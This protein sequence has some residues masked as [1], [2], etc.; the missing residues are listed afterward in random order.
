MATENNDAAGEV[1]EGSGAR[2][3]VNTC[4]RRHT[5]LS[6]KMSGLRRAP[7]RTTHVPGSDAS[8]AVTSLT[9]AHSPVS[10]SSVLGSVE[11]FIAAKRYSHVKMSASGTCAHRGLPPRV[12]TAGYHRP[13]G[14]C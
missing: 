2:V 6:K 13:G 7:I 11:R 10:G 12:T 4:P 9:P 8:R 1:V 14:K 3:A 5:C